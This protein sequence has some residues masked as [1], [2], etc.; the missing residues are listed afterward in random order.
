MI[1]LFLVTKPEIDDPIAGVFGKL[2]PDV[3]TLGHFIENAKSSL[4]YDNAHL[5]KKHP[6][7]RVAIACRVFSPTDGRVFINETP[8]LL[9]A[10]RSTVPAEGLQ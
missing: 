6:G 10:I 7:L 8:E 2:V 1:Y 9:A 3:E 5:F 4:A